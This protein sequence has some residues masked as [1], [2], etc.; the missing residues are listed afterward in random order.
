M[1]RSLFATCS[2][3]RARGTDLLAY[4]GF[5]YPGGPLSAQNGGFGWAGPWFTIAADSHAGP[6]SNRVEPG[7]LATEGVVPLGNRASIAAQRNRIRRSLATSVGSV[8]DAAGLVEN[9]DGVR[10]VGGDG[11]V[12]YVSFM[13]RVT[14]T[15]DGFY[16]LEL[17]RG[18]GNGNRVLCIGNGADGSGYAATSNVN[19]YGSKNGPELGRE[20]LETSFFVVKITFGVD[21]RDQVEIYRNPRSLRNENACQVDASLKGNFAF[22]RISIANFD[23]QKTHELDEIR[24]GTHFLACHGTLGRWSRSAPPVVDGRTIAAAHERRAAGRRTGSY[25]KTKLL[26]RLQRSQPPCLRARPV[27]TVEPSFVP[28]FRDESSPGGLSNEKTSCPGRHLFGGRPGARAANGRR[29]SC[30]R[31]VWPRSERPNHRNRLR[32][33]RE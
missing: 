14:A 15:D 17:H 25:L 6:D 21:N 28:L 32:R 1:K 13:Q 10:L 31:S 20:D 23:G 26:C 2:P 3:P 4:E 11:H 12:V 30:R 8:F 9:Q 33:Q 7:S 19:V 5:R 29:H 16:G 24:V 27:G 18:D 22:D